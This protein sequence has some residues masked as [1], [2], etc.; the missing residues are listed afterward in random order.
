MHENSQAN[1]QPEKR[2]KDRAS[3]NADTYWESR[4]HTSLNKSKDLRGILRGAGGAPRVERRWKTQG[5][6]A[7]C[8]QGI[9]ASHWR[10]LR[11]RV[12]RSIHWPGNC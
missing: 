11:N 4:L 10:K 8:G 6:G 1:A 2:D 3:G 12:F 5:K 7:V 9:N